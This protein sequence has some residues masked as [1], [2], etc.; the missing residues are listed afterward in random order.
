MKKLLIILLVTFSLGMYAQKE[1]STKSYTKDFSP[2]QQAILKTKKMALELDLNE[3]QQNQMLELN[4]KW[5][6]ERDK[7]MTANKDVNK[8]E[9]S[10]TDRFNMMISMLDKKMEHQKQVKKVLNADQYEMWKKS[11]K[12]KGD[13]RSYARQGQSNGKQ[14]QGKGKK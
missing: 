2:E 6:A 4:K 8:A 5:V 9:M 14:Y 12:N 1:K 13:Q 11:T 10:S 7:M 3:T